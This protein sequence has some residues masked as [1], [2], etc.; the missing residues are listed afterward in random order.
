MRFFT[1]FPRKHR[2]ICMGPLRLRDCASECTGRRQSQRAF[3]VV[4]FRFLPLRSEDGQSG[5]RTSLG[6]NQG[7]EHEPFL[8]DAAKHLVFEQRSSQRHSSNP[9]PSILIPRSASLHNASSPGTWRDPWDP[10]A[11]PWESRSAPLGLRTPI[12]N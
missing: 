11:T 3:V 9:S 1:T 12:L 4:C 8:E 2:R 6:T 5:A 7:L 10:L